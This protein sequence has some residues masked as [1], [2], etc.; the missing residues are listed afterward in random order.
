MIAGFCLV[1]NRVYY[2]RRKRRRPRVV[3]C[4]ISRAFAD[5]RE[6]EVAI[7]SF[8]FLYL[9]LYVDASRGYEG[10]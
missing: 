9:W 7:S 10:L 2:G 4:I 8:F 1:C 6:H 3:G 5:S